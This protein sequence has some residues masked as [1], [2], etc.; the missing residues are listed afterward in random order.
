M[1]EQVTSAQRSRCQ[2]VKGLH[3]FDTVTQGINTKQAVKKDPDGQGVEPNPMAFGCSNHDLRCL[4]GA[5]ADAAFRSAL[6]PTRMKKLQEEASVEFEP[7]PP[8]SLFF[9]DFLC[10]ACWWP[11]KFAKAARF[12]S[13]MGNGLTH[14]RTR[15][16]DR[17]GGRVRSSV[18]RETSL[19]W[20]FLCNAEQNKAIVDQHMTCKR[21]GRG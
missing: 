21:S 16:P 15:T 4:L 13:G 7:G 1:K 20:T 11:R 10:H 14:H 17:D 2:C 5:G 6:P 19:A 12:G 8:E 9:L 3:W 18:S